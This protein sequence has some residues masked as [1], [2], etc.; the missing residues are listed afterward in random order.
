MNSNKFNVRKYLSDMVF[1]A[2][3]GIVTTFSIVAGFEGAKLDM[4]SSNGHI[5]ILLFG[6]ANLFADGVSM[7]M[8]SFLSVRAGQDLDKSAK[9]KDS[10]LAFKH[11]LVTFGAFITFGTMPLLPYII[12]INKQFE[13]ASSIIFVFLALV[14]VGYMRCVVTKKSK[15]AT[16]GETLLVGGMASSVAYVVGLFF[17]I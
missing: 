3:D 12:T 14:L 11:G 8:G 17:R 15:I 16:I 1:G 4:L 6:L 7:G 5:V 13:F 9:S 10:H 2:N